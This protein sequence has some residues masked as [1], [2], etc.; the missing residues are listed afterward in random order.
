VDTVQE[1]GIQCSELHWLPYFDPSRFVVVDAMH[2]LFLGLIQEHFEIL[3]IRLKHKTG[4]DMTP[5]ISVKFVIWHVTQ[6]HG[7]LLI[8]Q[9]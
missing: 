2:N 4:G 7:K 1:T 8:E 5:A 6:D 3:G 9:A